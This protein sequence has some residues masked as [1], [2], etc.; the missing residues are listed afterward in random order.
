MANLMKGT[1]HR[2]V[3]E[4]LNAHCKNN[5]N[6]MFYFL[7]RDINRP[8]STYVQI[9]KSMIDGLETCGGVIPYPLILLAMSGDKTLFRIE[10]AK[11]F[12]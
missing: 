7:A 9:Q 2:G 1:R 3:H 11:I 5:D 10:L 6:E 12:G 8:P 4:S